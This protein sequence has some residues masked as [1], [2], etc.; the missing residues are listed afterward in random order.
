MFLYIVSILFRFLEEHA[1]AGHAQ[2]TFILH[3]VNCEESS[4]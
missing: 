1:E 2:R 3:A 4:L